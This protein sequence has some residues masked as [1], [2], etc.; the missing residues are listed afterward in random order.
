MQ[1]KVTKSKNPM[2]RITIDP[3][4]FCTSRTDSN[5]AK[6]VYTQN[7]SKQLLCL[8]QLTKTNFK[9]L[10]PKLTNKWHKVNEIPTNNEYMLKC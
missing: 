3:T 4:K 10:K 9:A 6:K 8:Q 2:K 7:F 5:S 1:Q